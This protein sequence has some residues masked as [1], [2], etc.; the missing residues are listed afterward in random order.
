MKDYKEEDAKIKRKLGLAISS[1]ENKPI[2][3]LFSGYY[4]DD[5]WDI[6]DFYIFI[7]HVKT[8]IPVLFSRDFSSLDI[9]GFECPFYP[10]FKEEG[11]YS[12]DVYWFRRM[13]DN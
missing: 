4:D 12:R 6:K 8:E 10:L 7:D 5:P 11:E 1:M 13:Y 2:A 9:D 3:L